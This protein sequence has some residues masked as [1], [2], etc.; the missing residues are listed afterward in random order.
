VA[1]LHQTLSFQL[2]AYLK[3]FD[4]QQAKMDISKAATTWQFQ[5]FIQMLRSAKKRD[6]LQLLKRAPEK[7]L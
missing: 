3:T 5:R 4:S 1:E 2:T 6:V 7:M